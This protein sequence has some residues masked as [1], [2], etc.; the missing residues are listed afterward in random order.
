[1]GRFGMQLSLL[2]L[3]IVALASQVVLF[4]V[5]WVMVVGPSFVLTWSAL[6]ISGV[7]VS[8]MGMLAVT[9]RDGGTR[10]LSM[11]LIGVVALAFSTVTIVV[12]IGILTAPFALALVVASTVMLIRNRR[13]A[14][15]E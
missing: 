10:W 4:F 5:H 12:S 9:A 1:M 11:G 7:C 3:F 13:S 6:A 2:L 14:P 15:S 8:L